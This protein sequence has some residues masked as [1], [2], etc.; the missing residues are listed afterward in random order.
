MKNRVPWIDVE[1]REG[2]ALGGV[3]EYFGALASVIGLP[4]TVGRIY[5]V[6][7]LSREAMTFNEVVKAAGI[8]KASASRG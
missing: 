7:F 1:E 6:L 3:A 5:G 4:R 8:S 2:C